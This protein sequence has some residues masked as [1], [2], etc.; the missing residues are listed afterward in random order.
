[1]S[2]RDDRR[3]SAR[4][5]SEFPLVL[6]EPSG[7]VLDDRALAHDLSAHGFK[8][9][10]QA[11]LQKGAAVRFRLSL[12]QAGE[13][14]GRGRVAWEQSTALSVW[15]GVEFQGLSW[16]DRRRVRRATHPR[17]VDWSVIAERLALGLFVVMATGVL[18]RMMASALWR[19]YLAALAPKAFACAA[20]GWALIVL[21]RPRR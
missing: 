8:A 16:A 15:L 9:E 10:T 14:A 5:L 1:V 13:V 19:G 2:P 17:D 3:R 4:L 21:L 6:M 18:G 7:T 20:L 11:R 12:D